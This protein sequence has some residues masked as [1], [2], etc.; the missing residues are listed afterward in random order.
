MPVDSFG[1]VADSLKGALAQ[2]EPLLTWNWL[3]VTVA[4]LA[5]AAI[6]GAIVGS[7]KWL[8]PRLGR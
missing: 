1:R 2:P 8:F 7:V 3:T 5:V 6:F 4:G